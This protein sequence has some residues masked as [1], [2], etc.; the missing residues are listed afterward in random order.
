MKRLALESEAERGAD[1]LQFRHCGLG[2]SWSFVVSVWLSVRYTLAV[3]AIY[4]S[5]HLSIYLG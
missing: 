4:L 1:S 2:W 5:I 3:Y